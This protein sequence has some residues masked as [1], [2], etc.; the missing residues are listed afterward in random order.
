VDVTV[1]VVSWNTLKLTLECLR[2]IFVSTCDVLFEVVL[3]DNGSSDGT[4]AAVSLEFPSVRIV[5]NADNRGFAAANNQGICVGVGRNILMLNSDTIVSAGA[6]DRAS[7][8]LDA[9]PGVGGVGVRLLNSDGS[10]QRS[11]LR[12]PSL[13]YN[14]LHHA[15][16][17]FG[18]RSRIHQ[19]WSS[20]AQDLDHGLVQDVPYVRG[21]YLMVPARVFVLAGQFDEAYF[22]YGE[23][24][25]LCWR[26]WKSGHRV[27][28]LP[29]ADVVHHGGGSSRNAPLVTCDRRIEGQVRYVYE[30][31][32]RVAAH[33]YL[34]MIIIWY[35]LIARV[36]VGSIR[37]REMAAMHVKHARK[38]WLKQVSGG[39][40]DD[41]C[42]N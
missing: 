28:Y 6:I 12:F 16:S 33:V 22:M 30:H 21:A 42:A 25:D 17:V 39:A 32:N 3:V 40:P 20:P 11:I 31:S 13:S 2:S 35:G 23:E 37:G 34:A 10:L 7:H 8:Y 18:V 15:S 26:I 4:V 1:I 38:F 29:I 27:V 5:A 36:S 9:N 14:V 41:H 19:R 24:A